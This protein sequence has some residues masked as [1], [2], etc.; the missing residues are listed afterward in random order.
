MITSLDVPLSGHLFGLAVVVALQF[1]PTSR[2]AADSMSGLIVGQVVDGQSGRPVPG[3][4]VGLGGPPVSRAM[5]LPRILTGD[6]GRFVFRGLRR[7]NYVI[8]AHKA[9]FAEGA[10]GRT[11]PAGPTASLPLADGERLG[12]AVI[13]L[14][15]HASISGTVVDESGEHL[16]GVRVQAY[17]RAVV[18]GRRRYVASGEAF[19]DDRGIYRVGG[20]IPGNYIVGA[21]ARHAAVATSMGREIGG[22][23]GMLVARN[24]GGGTR[25]AAT[26]VIEVGGAGYVLGNGTPTPP[27]PR[28]GRLAIYPPSFHPAAPAGDAATIIPL[29]PGVEYLSADMQLTPVP[30]VR[31]SGRV[32]G[33]EGTVTMT[34]LRLIAANTAEISLEGDSY[35]TMTD[36][37]GQFAFPAVPSG[38]Y[39]LRLAR[40]QAPGARPTGETPAAVVWADLPLSV[41]ADDI[42]DLAVPAL[43][44][45]R[46]GGRF[47]FEGDQA[48]LPGTLTGVQVSIEPADAT[49]A[50]PLQTYIVHPDRFGE[51]VSRGMPGGRYY[52]RIADSPPGWMF[53]AATV[54][55][56]DVADAPLA[57]AADILNVVITFS[58]RWSGLHGS[59]QNRQGPDRGAAVIVFSTDSETWASSGLSPRRVRTVRPGRTG[60]Y[61]LNL[62][63]GDYYVIAVPDAQAADWQDPAF[64][65][66]ASRVAARVTIGQ[67]ER[68]MQ[69]LRTSELR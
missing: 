17:R 60:E 67:G 47:V 50:G 66:A 2:Q 61:S 44:G 52:I 40:G 38:H 16:V 46:I 63:P 27:P 18:S 29:A 36:R 56:R 25:G 33:P 57:V 22:M 64:L 45:V 5:P 49:F 43:A 21:S 23:A 6:D 4:L 28:E 26:A 54:E 59:V 69:D 48:R 68:K 35:V 58:D 15:K 12:D 53:K 14:W 31:V 55:G 20:L 62:P 30:T 41:G 65:E 39:S 11:R 13:R 9:G 24:T 3:A 10:Y 51:F 37:A 42:A 34:A 7:G 8:T 1:G 19:T 32:V